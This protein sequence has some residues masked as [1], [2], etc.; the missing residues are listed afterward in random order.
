M[1][2]WAVYQ[3]CILVFGARSAAAIAS[4]V[5][6]SLVILL[7][8]AA[9]WITAERRVVR[10]LVTRARFALRQFELEFQFEP[11]ARLWREGF[12][13]ACSVLYF[14]GAVILSAVLFLSMR[15]DLEIISEG[16]YAVAHI[17]SFLLVPFV[18][19]L[20]R[21]VV[22]HTLQRIVSTHECARTRAHKHA[23][24]HVSSTCALLLK[25]VSLQRP[26]VFYTFVQLA[27]MVVLVLSYEIVF[28]KVD[29]GACSSYYHDFNWTVS[30]SLDN[31]TYRNT[32]DID[33]EAH[34]VLSTL[35]LRESCNSLV[36]ILACQMYACICM[37][38]PC[39][40]MH[41]HAWWQ[42]CS[43]P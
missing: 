38:K 26:C 19:S 30:V 20:P 2:S 5:L 35:A 28:C 42:D 3:A 4:R 32:T 25:Q 12:A 33:S 34:T 6:S 1:L 29:P 14:S 16:L 39:T 7:A 21:A 23:C 8:A 27:S 13:C 9:I 17:A 36:I 24:A 10:M 15:R 40:H 11:Y 22:G 31:K 43:I 18:D 37:W 41:M